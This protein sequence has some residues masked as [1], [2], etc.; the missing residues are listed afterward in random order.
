MQ[1][2]TYIMLKEHAKI[3]SILIDFENS[4]SSNL[5]EKKSAINNLKWNLDKH[6]FIEEKVIF[7]IFSKLKEDDSRDVIELLKQHKDILWLIKNIQNS[8]NSNLKP[9]IK[10][11]KN[12]LRI[13]IKLENNVFY[14]NLDKKLDEKSKQII[15]ERVEEKFAK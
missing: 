11:L 5:K 8:L 15:L 12:I 3:D 6:F 14:P 10:E 7:Q 13:H 1:E 2:I 4:L 9:N